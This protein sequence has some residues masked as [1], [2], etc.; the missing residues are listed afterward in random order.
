MFDFDVFA[1][2]MGQ[3]AG[4]GSGGGA[5]A[6]WNAKEGEAGYIKNRTH[7]EEEGVLVQ[8][9]PETKV[10]I[11]GGQ[12]FVENVLPLADGETCVVSW[13]GVEF[14]C[15]GQDD[16]GGV[17]VGDIYTISGGAK[18]TESTGEPFFITWLNG[19][20]MIFC[21]DDSAEV[22]LSIVAK[23]T[24]INKIDQ[25]YLPD[26]TK[27]SDFYEKG[28]IN[29]KNLFEI[30][31]GVEFVP[32]VGTTTYGELNEI[33]ENSVLFDI[34]VNDNWYTAVKMRVFTSFSSISRDYVGEC[35]IVALDSDGRGCSVNMK[36]DG[37]DDDSVVTSIEVVYPNSN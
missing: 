10:A 12:G 3:K 19:A 29:K 32:E 17:C 28:I 8:L 25:K 7:W 31:R 34:C 21:F 30:V 37:G 22:D 2:R 6:D 26:I 20:I 1:Y 18:G 4:G 13:N 14:E 36:C 27:D 23:R 16:G 9:L 5:P 11:E 24:T 33:K 35:Y 15:V